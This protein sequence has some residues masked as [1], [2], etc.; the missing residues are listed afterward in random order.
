MWRRFFIIKLYP[1]KYYLINSMSNLIKIVCFLFTFHGFAQVTTSASVDA[2]VRVV[3][4]IRIN[5]SVDLNF[6]NVISGYNPGSLTLFPD[7]T[8]VPNG[9]MISNAIPG[10]V[11]PAE[12]IVTHGNNNYSITLPESFILFNQDNPNQIITIDQF[13]VE[14]TPE[15]DLEGVDIL[16]IGATLNLEANQGSGYYTNSGGFNITVSYN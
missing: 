4:P 12:A 10:E 3:E 11:T 13:T 15:V 9:I 6:G 5:K 7:G 16:K 2:R 14:P 1:D 8:R